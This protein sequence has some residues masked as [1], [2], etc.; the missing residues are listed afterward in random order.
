MMSRQSSYQDSSL[1]DEQAK[2]RKQTIFFTPLNPC[3]DNPD[4]EEEQ[5]T[6]TASAHLVRTP[7]TGS[8]QPDRKKRD[9]SLGRQEDLMTLLYTIL[10]WQIASTK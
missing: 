1:D 4:E 10:C 8:I 5:Y 7:P 9:C 2:K 6:T 3:G